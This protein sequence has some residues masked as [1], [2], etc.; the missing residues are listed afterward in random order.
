MPAANNNQEFDQSLVGVKVKIP[1]IL[2]V[3]G[4]VNL[5]VG[6]TTLFV[7]SALVLT[8]LYFVFKKGR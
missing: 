2:G 6:N 5:S 8:T 4:A 1:D 7:V 3:N